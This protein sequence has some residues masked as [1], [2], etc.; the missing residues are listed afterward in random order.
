M[1]LINKVAII[2]GAASTIGAAIATKFVKNGAKVILA[3]TRSCQGIAD[4]LNE[5]YKANHSGAEV[6]VARAK[7]CD[8]R[9]PFNILQAIDEAKKAYDGL[10]IF[11]NNAEVHYDDAPPIDYNIFK[12]TMAVNVE[13]VLASIKYA[14]AEMRRL[15]TD[16]TNRG[17]ILCTGTT[18]KVLLSGGMMPSAYSISKTAVIDVVRAA[19]TELASDGVRVHS[20]SARYGLA[21]E[22]SMLNQTY[23][24]ANDT[25]LDAM[26]NKY[27]A[28]KVAIAE[29]VANKAVELASNAGFSSMIEHELNVMIPRPSAPGE[30][31]DDSSVQ[32]QTQG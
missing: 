26:F 14:A 24:K 4:K 18:D 27:K 25:T 6:E 13:S 23:P 21:P 11:Y 31:S 9:D 1:A 15:N 10:H 16:S 29:E 8:V 3:D 5:D 30:A 12:K 32:S 7:L 20:I 2:T 17:C 19:A 22:R 28:T